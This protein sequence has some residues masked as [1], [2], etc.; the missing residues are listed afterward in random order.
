MG[1]NPSPGF[2][3]THSWARGRFLAF[4]AHL[5]DEEEE[6]RFRNHLAE[7]ASCRETATEVLEPS[8]T[9]LAESGHI[10]P[11]I[12]A[13]WTQAGIELR[14]LERAMVRRHLERC[15]ECRRELQLLGF[16][17]V[18]A[19]TPEDSRGERTSLLSRLRT[20]FF[21]PPMRT[22]HLG[23]GVAMAIAIVAV[24]VGV[25][26]RGETLSPQFARLV[27]GRAVSMTTIPAGRFLPALVRGDEPQDVP[28][29]PVEAA[30]REFFKRVE[31]AGGHY[32]LVPLQVPTAPAQH[33]RGR[34]LLLVDARGKGIG[35][36]RADLPGDAQTIQAWLLALPTRQLFL[37]DMPSDSAK[38]EW[39]QPPGGWTCGTFTCK[40]GPG[41]LASPAESLRSDW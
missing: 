24:V 1:E 32:R 10:P 23:V 26:Q 33:P 7:C 13:R 11:S 8:P 37:V 39:A 6:A 12:L 31:V 9:D 40:M 16:E 28:R 36:L 2:A 22:W 14:G 27:S 19:I 30:A 3:A 25:R 17:P 18:L 38:I 35:L 15:A 20:R 5:L 41:F 4:A 21:V 29:S 34:L